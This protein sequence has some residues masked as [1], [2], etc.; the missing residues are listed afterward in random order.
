M[1]RRSDFSSWK[2]PVRWKK[3]KRRRGRSRRIIWIRKEPI[4]RYGPFVMNT[5]E[6]LYQAFEDYRAGRMGQTYP[7]VLNAANEVAVMAFLDGRI[8]LVQIP[9]VVGIVLDEHEPAP[10]V[11]EVTLSRADRWA[12]ERSDDVI[13]SL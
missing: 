12:R 9:E 5:K 1:N 10:I 3:R 11:S 13:R 7:A 2:S 4:A 6:E 8:R